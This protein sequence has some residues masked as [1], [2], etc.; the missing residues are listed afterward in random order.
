MSW[1]SLLAA[2][3]T[4]AEQQQVNT[5]HSSPDV[6]RLTMDALCEGEDVFVVECDGDCVR[7]RNLHVHSHAC[8]WRHFQCANLTKSEPQSECACHVAIATMQR[9]HGT[10]WDFSIFHG[11]SAD[12]QHFPRVLAFFIRFQH[13]QFYAIKFSRT[14]SVFATKKE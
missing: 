1:R 11:F 4:A 3:Y 2:V 8:M 14:L 5:V 9:V 12:F 6:L 13:Y 10:I 7:G